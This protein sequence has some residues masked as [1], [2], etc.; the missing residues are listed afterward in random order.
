MYYAERAYNADY[1]KQ[2]E[3]EWLINRSS[4]EAEFKC[5]ECRYSYID[6]DSYAKVEYNYCP[7]CGAHMRKEDEGK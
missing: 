3:G 7:N 6:A 5:S 4:V 1:R 2:S